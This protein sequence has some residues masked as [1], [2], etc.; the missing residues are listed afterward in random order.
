M[1]DSWNPG[2]SRGREY[3]DRLR[4]EGTITKWDGRHN[5]PVRDGST[6]VEREIDKIPEASYKGLRREQVLRRLE[7]YLKQGQSKRDALARLRD[8]LRPDSGPANDGSKLAILA[9]GD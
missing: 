1:E 2:V 7:A 9:K 3:I 4:A 5:R 8:S 6:W